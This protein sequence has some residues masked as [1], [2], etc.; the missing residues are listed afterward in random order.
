MNLFKKRQYITITPPSPVPATSAPNV[1]D[2]VYLKCP[3]CGKAVYGR[4][5]GIYRLCP[6]KDCGGCFRLSASERIN[7]TADSGTFVE[8]D[9][10][11]SALNPVD[12]PNYEAKIR[13]TIPATLPAER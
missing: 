8:H 1:P 7:I 12:Y 3:C 13:Q 10:G 9:A 2:G 5:L 4:Q 6:E 11:M